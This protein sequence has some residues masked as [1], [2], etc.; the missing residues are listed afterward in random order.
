MKGVVFNA[1]EAAVIELFDEDTWD[2]IL[3]A[4]GVEGVYS[5]VGS[6]E[7]SEMM[8][9]VQAASVL[10]ELP[11]EAVLIAV[12]RKALT[13]LADRVP[14]LLGGCTNSFEM[15]RLIHDVIHV[16]V[17][18]LY[19]DALTPDF[20]Y[21]ELPGDGLRLGY[22]S[23]RPLSALAEGLIH[24]VGDRFGETLSV[25]RQDP[26]ELGQ[27]TEKGATEV[28][29]IDVF[30]EAVV[31]SNSDSN[32]EADIARIGDAASTSETVH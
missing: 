6:Y 17:K 26:V 13:H 4:A 9:I 10:T 14:E 25:T 28:I 23:H 11:I 20:T 5:S 8:A 12:G 27:A 29:Y 30:V 7:D 2:D 15:L 32:A 18:K 21:E 1:A 31:D 19:P 3:D 16:E 22:H 24:G